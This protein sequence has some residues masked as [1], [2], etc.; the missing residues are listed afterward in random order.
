M[1]KIKK[2]DSNEEDSCRIRK[3]NRIVPRIQM[4]ISSFGK[5]LEEEGRRTKN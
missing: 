4:K 1:K 2:F 5:R 3:A